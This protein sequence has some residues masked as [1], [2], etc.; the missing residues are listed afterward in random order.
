MT[1]KVRIATSGHEFTVDDSESV[2]D[3]ALRQGLALPY[4]CRGGTGGACKGKVVLGEGAY[5]H[6]TPPALSAV[7]QAAGM[8][9]FCLAQPRGDIVIEVREPHSASERAIKKLPARVVKK[10]FL[11]PDVVRLLLLLFVAVWLL[12]LVGFF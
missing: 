10:E 11:A 5:P 8:A 12:F 9:L 3:A 1:C 7:E 4:R 6:G 2:L